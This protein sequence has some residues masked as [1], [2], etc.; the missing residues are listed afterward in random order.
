[1]HNYLHNSNFCCTFARF[2]NGRARAERE[3]E[4]S[5]WSKEPHSK[6]GVP[7][8]RYRGFESLT[9]RKEKRTICLSEFTQASKSLFFSLNKVLAA[10]C[11]VSRWDCHRQCRCPR[12]P[13]RAF[14]TPNREFSA[15]SLCRLLQAI[16]LSRCARTIIAC[17]NCRISI[18]RVIPTNCNPC[19][20]PQCC[21]RNCQQ[22][23]Q[24]VQYSY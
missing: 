2:F 21:D 6:C 11:W 3:G 24:Q 9:L 12:I 19:R 5:E 4:L 23:L 1:M 20:H 14:S 22:Q 7:I 13:V 8:Y 18:F 10:A 17:G 16:F 15:A